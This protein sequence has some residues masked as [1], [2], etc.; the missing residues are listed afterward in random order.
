MSRNYIFYTFNSSQ[1]ASIQAHEPNP[2][3]TFDAP[4]L[5]YN[6]VDRYK[7]GADGSVTYYDN[8]GGDTVDYLFVGGDLNNEI[9][10][11]DTSLLKNIERT[12]YTE[13]NGT[14]HNLQIMNVSNGSF[15]DIKSIFEFSSSNS[16]SEFSYQ[17][18]LNGKKF[19]NTT[20]LPSAELSATTLIRRNGKLLHHVHS[21]PGQDYF[22]PSP[23]DISSA[24]YLINKFGTSLEMYSPLLG[25]YKNYNGESSSFE[26]EEIMLTPKNKK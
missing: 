11:T 14:K 13:S 20:F 10:V 15:K 17:S 24:S 26:L 8:K 18:F 5:Q 4:S 9:M 19:I 1:N 7:L 25:T 22:A 16:S 3:Y 21:H 2:N 12:T 23:G 6:P